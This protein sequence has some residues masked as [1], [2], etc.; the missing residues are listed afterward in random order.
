MAWPVF[1]PC[2]SSFGFL[3]FITFPS[4]GFFFFFSAE[5]ANQ[6]FSTQVSKKAIIGFSEKWITQYEVYHMRENGMYIG[7]PPSLGIRGIGR[8]KMW[9][10]L[11]LGDLWDNLSLPGATGW[12]EKSPDVGWREL[13]PRESPFYDQISACPWA[14][15]SIWYSAWT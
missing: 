7:C 13:N 11:W 10:G 14:L 15:S 8:K 1:L 6:S 4:Y 3:S 2:C 5:I 12:E 9:L